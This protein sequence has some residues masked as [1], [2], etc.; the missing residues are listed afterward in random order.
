MHNMNDLLK[1]NTDESTG[2]SMSIVKCSSL[3]LPDYAVV[4]NVRMLCKLN[5]PEFS[6]VH[7]LLN[8][9]RLANEYGSLVNAEYI[10]ENIP[11]S[12]G[13]DQREVGF[14]YSKKW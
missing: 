13:Y 11:G 14:N 5:G 4:F 12:W 10:R 6:A 2:S 7:E 1:R 8:K 3:R 9:L